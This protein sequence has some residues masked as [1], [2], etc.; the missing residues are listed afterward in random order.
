MSEK[1]GSSGKNAKTGALKGK[2]R[3]TRTVDRKSKASPADSKPSRP[4][5]NSGERAEAAGLSKESEQI[6]AGWF[7]LWLMAAAFGC[8]KQS[9]HDHIRPLVDK[10]DVRGAGERGTLL[11]CRGVVDA[12][13]KHKLKGVDSGE[14]GINF[15]GT[16]SPWIEVLRNT[17]RD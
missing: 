9:L 10:T 4:R 6:A 14:A 11:R 13:V 15:G 12:W 5:L 1:R 3:S 8:S 7:P 17:T 16:D 2:K